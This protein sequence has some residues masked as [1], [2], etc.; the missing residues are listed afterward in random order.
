MATD[1]AWLHFYCNFFSLKI[2][3]NRGMFL[4]ATCSK[5]KAITA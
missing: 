1:Q 5:S 4:V 3:R 2:S